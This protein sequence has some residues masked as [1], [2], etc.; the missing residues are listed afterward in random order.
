MQK[1]VSVNIGKV[2]EIALSS[3]TKDGQWISKISFEG[4]FAISDVARILN[5]S[6]Q[7]CPI[8]VIFNSPQA[9]LD[10]EVSEIDVG[11]GV[12]Q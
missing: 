6:R 7:A 12:V 8:E 9:R 4:E 1:E 5:L 10:L 3:K 2:S 11:T